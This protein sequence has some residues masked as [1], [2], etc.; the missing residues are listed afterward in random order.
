MYRHWLSSPGR[1]GW[2][3]GKKP[4]GCIF[5]GMAAGKKDVPSKILYKG[6]GFMVVMNIFP[7]NTGH[8]QVIPSGTSPPLRK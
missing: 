5:C 7:Y 2:V 6:R 1:M 3:K 4:E 8:M